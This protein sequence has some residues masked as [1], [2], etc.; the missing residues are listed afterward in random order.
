MG[1][2]VSK[3]SP[4]NVFSLASVFKYIGYFLSAV[5]VVAVIRGVVISNYKAN[6]DRQ[7]MIKSD[8]TLIHEIRN[9]NSKVGTIELDIRDIKFTQKE[10]IEAQNSLRASYILHLRDDKALTTD[11]FIRYMDGIQFELKK[12]SGTSMY[13]TPSEQVR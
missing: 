3:A 13:M 5:A 12:N 7:T 11:E 10:Q 9:L 2:K 8:S 6:I 4:T 1:P